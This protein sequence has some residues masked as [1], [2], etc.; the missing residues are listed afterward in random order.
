LAI[1][2]VFRLENVSRSV[3]IM[4]ALILTIGVVSTR[5]SFRL[6]RIWAA[7]FD[8]PFE[9]KRVLIYGAGDAGELL[10]RELLQNRDLGLH[11]VGLVDDDPQKE[12]R[13]IH[14]IR[15]LRGLDRLGELAGRERVD[16]VVVSTG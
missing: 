11:P 7:P 13:V 9:G 5:I 15:V 6:M 8:T 1:I 2:F 3:L 14:G 4:D 10:L 16:E 12:G